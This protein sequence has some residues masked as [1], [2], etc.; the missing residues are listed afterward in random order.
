[1]STTYVVTIDIKED[2]QRLSGFPMVKTVTVAE[3]KGKQVISR[4]DA[5]NTFTE[6]PVQELGSIELLLVTADQAFNLRFND[7]SDSNLPVSS[8]GLVLLVDC[9]IP[10][11][12][13][14]KVALE[15]ESGSAAA[16][17]VL[18]GGS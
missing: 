6:L 11:G 10:S 18:S 15:N 9:D 14:N 2:G 1:M 17:T 16:V 13:S 7:Q 8:G 4:A 3:T 12:A 5:D